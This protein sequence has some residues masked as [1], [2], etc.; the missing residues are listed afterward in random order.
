MKKIL[1]ALLSS[2][3]ILSLAATVGA[4]NSQ[5]EKSYDEAADGE[6]LYVVDFS[7]TGG[8]FNPGS[9]YA[10]VDALANHYYTP[11][12]DG[13]TVE[14]TPVEDGAD[15]V[16][17]VW[18]GTIEGLPAN[19]KTSY[20]MVYKVRANGEYGKNNSIGVGGWLTGTEGYKFYSNYG[21]HNTMAE[22]GSVYTERRTALSSTNIKV[23]EYV[24]G[25]QDA[26]EDDDG[27]ITMMIEFDGPTATM[28]GYVAMAD[29]EDG[30]DWKL[31]E[32]QP[33]A[34]MS[35]DDNM[36]LMFYVYYHNV[37][38]TVSNVR[39]FKGIGLTAEQINYDP[40]AVVEEVETV[41]VA[42]A[43]ET[44]TTAPQTFD[45][46]VIAVIGAVVSACG[47]TLT[48]KR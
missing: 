31:L 35:D 10:Q 16:L 6:L 3:L 36:C 48:K 1:T 9:C 7:S 21:N 42:D 8:A 20:T 33:M 13:L 25:V 17:N 15:G 2:A 46:G 34:D 11:E 26:Y 27:F 12:D 47:Y 30:Y 39:Y 22:D 38:H 24:Y 40:N 19:S 44:T 28:N 4:A 29:A 23:G 32:T 45:A 18:G 14:I 41:A 37:E 5:L 43:T